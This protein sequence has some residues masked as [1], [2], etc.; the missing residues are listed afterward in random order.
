LATKLKKFNISI[1]EIFQEYDA[2]GNGR[3]S[4]D[5]IKSAMRKH[6][7]INL[8]ESEVKLLKDFFVSKFRTPE[9]KST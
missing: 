5:E 1:G 2:D 4:A 8:G 6:V 9:I 7:Q 3:L